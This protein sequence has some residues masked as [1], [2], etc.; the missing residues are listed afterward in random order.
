MTLVLLARLKTVTRLPT[1]L[2]SELPSGVN[3]TL[4]ARSTAHPAVNLAPL[5]SYT[6]AA[7]TFAI[8]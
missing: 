2:I 5:A 7:R 8:H 3:A 4:P 1:G 6:Q